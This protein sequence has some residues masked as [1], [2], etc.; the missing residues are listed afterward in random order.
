M[1]R[2]DPEL[3][4]SLKEALVSVYW[5]KTDLNTFLRGALTD[6]ALLGGINWDHHQKR[7]A[8]DIVVNRIAAEPE[9]YKSDLVGLLA[10]VSD[11]TAFPHL[12][13]LE[14]GANKAKRASQAVA[15]LRARATKVRSWLEEE[16][17]AGIRKEERGQREKQASSFQSTLQNLQ[18]HFGELS[19]MPDTRA[20]GYKL[21]ALLRDL[22]ELFDLD[23]KASF[24]LVGEQ[25][26]GAFTF[27]G[28]DFLLEAKWQ[29][30]QTGSADLD[31][32]AN[33]VQR[34]LE[35]TLGLFV[36]MGGYSP[37]GISAHSQ[38]HKVL[39]LIDGAHLAAILEG[40]LR[41][42]DLLLRARR[43]AS[44]TGEIYLPFS[45]LF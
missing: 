21:E 45:E 17:K 33:R 13:R 41:L 10:A 40:R 32:F 38:G 37:D 24:K 15:V 12:E 3:L 18:V 31:T 28:T 2:V 25:I 14:D 20:R 16:T 27:D 43:H 44:Q 9:T 5:Y 26:D 39:L 34:K 1:K 42:S 23:P 35:N 6:T 29:K 19:K 7:E 36:S 4:N 8:I 11:M 30:A 22:F